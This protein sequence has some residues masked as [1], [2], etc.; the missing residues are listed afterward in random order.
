VVWHPLQTDDDL[1]TIA[2][3]QPATFRIPLGREVPSKGCWFLVS[4]D[5]PADPANL[6]SGMPPPSPARELMELVAHDNNLAL[7]WL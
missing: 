5:A 3:N 7:A 6:A 4:A 1:Q 2:G